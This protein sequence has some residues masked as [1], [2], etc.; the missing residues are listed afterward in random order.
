MSEPPTMSKYLDL[1]FKSSEKKVVLPGGIRRCE[2]P[3]KLLKIRAV[4]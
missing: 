3:F 2:D 1:L 4:F